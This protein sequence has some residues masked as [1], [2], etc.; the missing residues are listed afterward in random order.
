MPTC[1]CHLEDDRG[2]D[3]GMNNIQFEQRSVIFTEAN[4]YWNQL[5]LGLV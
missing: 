4:D 3:G 2:L 1:L 5:A